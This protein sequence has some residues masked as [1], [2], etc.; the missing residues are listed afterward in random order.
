[1]RAEADKFP[2]VMYTGH[3]FLLLEKFVRWVASDMNIVGIM[4]SPSSSKVCPI[5]V[6]TLWTA[7]GVVLM[8]SGGDSHLPFPPPVGSMYLTVDTPPMFIKRLL[9]GVQKVLCIRRLP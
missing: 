5:A 1:M 2:I 7:S 8:F 6:S 4:V 9:G 3:A